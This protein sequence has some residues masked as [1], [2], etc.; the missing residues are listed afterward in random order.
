MAK[1][2]TLGL[3][4]GSN[5]QS[6]K[7]SLFLDQRIGFSSLENLESTEQQVLEVQQVNLTQLENTEQLSNKDCIQETSNNNNLEKDIHEP[8]QTPHLDALVKELQALGLNTEGKKADLIKRLKRFKKKQA[9][10]IKQQTRLDMKREQEQRQ[11]P[12]DYYLICDVEGTCIEN[13]GFDYESEIIEF[14]VLL[15]QAETMS[16]ID[17][18][19]AYV[20]PLLHPE[21]SEFC[22]SF[23]GITQETVDKSESFYKVFDQFL[24]WLE[25]HIEPPF[26][27][28]IFVTDGIWDLRDFVQKELT[29]MQ[30][31]RP[32]FMN[33]II[34]I[35]K[36]FTKFYSRDS[37]NLD[38]MLRFLDL[39]FEGREHSGIDDTKNVAKIFIKMVQDGHRMDATTNLLK[40]KI[41]GK[42][43][44]FRKPIPSDAGLDW[45]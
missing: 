30:V 2:E 8:S 39:S 24:S 45:F 19:H 7:T 42:W 21:L 31:S 10:S 26:K 14:P 37:L 6:K 38:G 15:I 9:E 43:S 5:Q 44:E 23:T 40:H 41:K 11:L 33:Q 22:K 12:Y 34:D 28:C 29:Y 3:A 16:I 27:N 36:K 25:K 32:P 13:S 35:R 18:F 1:V 20:R 17:Q 4:S